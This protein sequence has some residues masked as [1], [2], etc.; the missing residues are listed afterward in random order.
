MR[1]LLGWV[2]VGAMAWG[3]LE[4][5]R[6]RSWRWLATMVFLPLVG[7]MAWFVAGRAH[8][9]YGRKPTPFAGH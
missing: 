6:A 5:A 1:V 3:P 7:T 8:Y 9:G 4:A 2:L